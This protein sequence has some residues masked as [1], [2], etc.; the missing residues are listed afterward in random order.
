M[1]TTPAVTGRERRIGIVGAG[2]TGT[3][4]AVH[5]MRL[6]E[7]P[8]HLFLMERRGDFGRGVAYSTGNDAHLLNVR[9]FNMS[10]YPDDPKHFLRWLWARDDPASPA[11][12]SRRA[13]TPSSRA[14][15]TALT[16]TSN[17][18]WRCGRLRSM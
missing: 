7:R 5:L 6:A 9:V 13:A 15:F 10:A 8:T 11:K 16:S 4:L 17:S 18:A 3:L 1:G 14:G 2:F 12:R